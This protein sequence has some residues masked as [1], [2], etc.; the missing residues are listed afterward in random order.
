MEVFSLEEDDGASMF[1]TQTPVVNRAVQN[2]GIL[3]DSSDFS[4]PCVGL[5][6][7][8]AK[9]SDISDDDFEEFPCSQRAFESDKDN[10]G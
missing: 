2:L 7:G 3:G 6:S 5:V 4:S 10:V 8:E 1:L 9:Y